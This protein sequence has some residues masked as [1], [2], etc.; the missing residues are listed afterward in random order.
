MG[1][2][3]TQEEYVKELQEVN[4]KL[5]IEQEVDFDKVREECKILC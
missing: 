5:D 4:P 1:R 2:L 3:K